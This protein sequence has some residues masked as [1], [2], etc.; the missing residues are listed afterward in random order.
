MAQ[1]LSLDDKREITRRL[2]YRLEARDGDQRA[3]LI[4]P[5]GRHKG[6]FIPCKATD[7]WTW[8]EA[9]FRYRLSRRRDGGV[10]RRLDP[11][12]VEGVVGRYEHVWP[13]DKAQS[14]LPREEFEDLG[15]TGRL[16]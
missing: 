15:A 12:H 5:E 1:P 14:E 3:A 9:V 10:Y 4:D 13:G 16:T 2:G 8:N 11:P 7:V 6:L